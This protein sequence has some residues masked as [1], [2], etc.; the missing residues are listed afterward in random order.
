MLH[1]PL[2]RRNDDTAA[3]RIVV[4]RTGTTV[5]RRGLL[6]KEWTGRALGA[7]IVS[8]AYMRDGQRIVD[9]RCWARTAPTMH[10]CCALRATA[11]AQDIGFA[12]RAAMYR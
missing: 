7:P 5:C 6:G 3:M 10:A 1:V 11:K 12:S 4:A 2:A 9:R 8:G